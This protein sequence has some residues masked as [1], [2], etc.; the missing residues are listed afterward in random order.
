[1]YTY[2]HCI[3]GGMARVHAHL[4]ILGATFIV[5]QAK[6]AEVEDHVHHRFLRYT[7]HVSRTGSL[8]ALTSI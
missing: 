6:Q 8:G 4:N 1:M 7:F 2:M 5:S 3:V